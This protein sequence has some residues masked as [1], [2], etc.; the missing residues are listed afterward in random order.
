MAFEIT[1]D[2]IPVLDEWGWDDYWGIA[3]W[4]LWHSLMV[5]KYGKD[6]A[7]IK[8]EY[9]WNKQD[10]FSSPY[11]WAKYNPQFVAYLKSNGIDIG[12]FISTPVIGAGE[13]IKDV[14]GAVTNTTKGV[15][16][17]TNILKWVIPITFFAIL[18]FAG[19][20]IYKKYK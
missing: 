20:V 13:V 19:F 16:N 11:N 8:F 4:Q 7:K 6:S 14:T 1:A 12:N 9:Y 15:L 5:K 3:E 10:A 18:I 2:S 17:T